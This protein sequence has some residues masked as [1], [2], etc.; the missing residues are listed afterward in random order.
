MTTSSS[1][2]SGGDDGGASGE[3]IVSGSSTVEPIS[4]AVAEALEDGGSAVAVDVDGPGTGDGFE[5]FCAGETDISDASRPIDEEEIAACEDA[6]IEFIELEVAIDGISVLTNPANDAVDCLSFADL[7]ALI[8]PESADVDNWCD[9]AA[10][11]RGARLDHRVPGCAARH[12]RSRC[13]VGHLRQLHRA[14]ARAMAEIRLEAGDIDEEQAE[15]PIRQFPGQSDDNV[16][17][18]G[19]E[20]SDSSLR[21]GRLRLRRGRG[22][23][24]EGAR[25]RRGARRRV[26]RPD[27]RDD[28]RRQLPRLAGRSTST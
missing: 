16:I 8:G 25:D 17:I 7:Y 14:R 6:G 27:G 18:Q 24:R 26:R 22:R 23:R 21:L 13:G 15:A 9:A 5:L 28:R 11:R 3:V 2:D 4:V 1:D 20:G 19:I 10:A 12:H